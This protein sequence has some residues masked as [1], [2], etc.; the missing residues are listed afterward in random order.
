MSGFS[1]IL[2]F[3][4]CT[5]EGEYWTPAS[6]VRVCGGEG[7]RFKPFAG[8]GTKLYMNITPINAARNRD[9]I[10]KFPGLT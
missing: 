5:I 4:V 8:L 7:R 1:C 2:L 9:D 6:C 3:Q 10:F